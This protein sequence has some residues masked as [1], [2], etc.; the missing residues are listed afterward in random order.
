MGTVVL[1][2]ATPPNVEPLQLAKGEEKSKG[3]EKK[4]IGVL[5][6]DLASVSYKISYQYGMKYKG[7]GNYLANVKFTPL[8][9]SSDPLWK[10]S[11][12][13]VSEKPTNVG[14]AK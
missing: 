14:D 8:T 13:A 2:H 10:I 5:G 6:N 3:F 4:L 1:G 7:A 11:A 9:V 12:E